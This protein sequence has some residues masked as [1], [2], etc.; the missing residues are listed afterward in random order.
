MR[1]A[2]EQPGVALRPWTA[3][4]LPTLCRNVNSRAVWRNLTDPTPPPYTED[5]IKDWIATVTTPS[6]STYLAI[7]VEGESA[8]AI[9][10]EA[11]EGISC[12]TG[13]FGYWLAEAYWGRGIA[14]AAVRAM[15]TFAAEHLSFA[16]L[17]AVVFAW[18][19]PSMRVLEKSGFVREGVLRRSVFKDGEIIDKIMY[20]HLI[21]T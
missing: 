13:N 20:A 5:V 7:E 2:T 11:F 10:I 8:G 9:A 3:E 19:P 18:N 12:R 14:T 6:R 17:E 21:G 16:R 1:I 4:D 15:V